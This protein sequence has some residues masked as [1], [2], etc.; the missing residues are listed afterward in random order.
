MR[1][2]ESLAAIQ[3]H[4]GQS[5]DAPESLIQKSEALF[6]G[7]PYIARR[8]FLVHS[9]RLMHPTRHKVTHTR[10][11]AG[12]FLFQRRNGGLGRIRTPDPLVRSQVL[13]PTELPVRA[14]K[15]A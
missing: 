13:Y 8:H 1:G 15:N 14:E 2:R 5:P 3:V 9:R 11:R 4:Q 10:S 12:Y 7:L 6:N